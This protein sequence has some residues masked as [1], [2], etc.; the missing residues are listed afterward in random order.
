M[1]VHGEGDGPTVRPESR[2]HGH[3]QVYGGESVGQR[4]CPAFESDDRRRRGEDCD[5][6]DIENAVRARLDQMHKMLSFGEGQG[7]LEPPVA[8]CQSRMARATNP[9]S[10]HIGK[11]LP[12]ASTSS[13]A[14]GTRRFHS[15]WKP[16]GSFRLPKIVS[17]GRRSM[18]V[19]T[20]PSASRQSGSLRRTAA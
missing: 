3:H 1:A 17:S 18:T 12:P 14:C 6:H 4:P 10:S 8:R 13:D 11:W 7:T 19:L 16:N 5:G 9:G 15:A 20:T 2:R